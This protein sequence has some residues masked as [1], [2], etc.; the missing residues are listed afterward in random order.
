MNRRVR[1]I[2]N[3]GKAVFIDTKW[4][5]ERLRDGFTLVAFDEEEQDEESA[6]IGL[7]TL[8]NLDTGRH[9]IVTTLGGVMEPAEWL[10]EE[11]WLADET[12]F[13]LDYKVR[14]GRGTDNPFSG[15]ST[16]ETVRITDA[17]V[18]TDKDGIRYV[19]ITPA[20]EVETVDV[21]TSDGAMSGGASASSG[22]ETETVTDGG[23]ETMGGDPALA[24][25][26][27]KSTT[28]VR[29]AVRD[30]LRT[31]TEPGDTVTAPSVAGA[32]AHPP[33]DVAKIL[34]SIAT[35]GSHLTKTGGGY[36]ER[37]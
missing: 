35:K 15:V 19:E 1:G 7:T 21:E 3:G 34:K 13:T 6:D 10:T 30:Y 12:D 37:L 36:Y 25:A 2:E 26:G 20:C 24:D 33:E 18:K 9:E 4:A 23:A 29:T 16:G 14:G 17:R 11:G 32:V 5:A 27:D 8:A 31:A 22:S 28:P